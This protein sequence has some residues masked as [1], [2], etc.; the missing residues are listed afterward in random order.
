MEFI[1]ELEKH[2]KRRG[3]NFGSIENFEAWCDEVQP[4]LH[5]SQK[6]ERVFDQAIVFG[7]TIKTASELEAGV[8]QESSGVA[9]PEKVT[10]LW[11]VKHVEVKHWLG[12][13]VFIIAVFTAGIKVGNS[14]F[15]QDYFQASSAVVE[16]K[17]N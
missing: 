14:A 13:A 4:L 17:T 5:F 8:Q 12:A 1:E 3:Y 10:L 9:Y 2:Q 11:L 16:T 6:H 15:Y 7:K